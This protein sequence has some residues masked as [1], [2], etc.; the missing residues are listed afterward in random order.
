M[1]VSLKKVADRV[2]VS[3]TTVSL[4][5]RG[6]RK[7]SD[8]T[9]RKVLKV[10]RELGY[11]PNASAKA[12]VTGWS[13][14]LGVTIR[15]IHYLSD[16]YISSIMAGVAEV[17]DEK[18]LSLAF[19]R[20]G[21]QR[22]EEAEYIQF[23]REGRFAG[24]I[25]I[26]QMAS[27]RELRLLAEMNVPT[28]LVDRR[29]PGLD[30]PVVRVN[31]CEAARKATSHLIGL[32]HKRIGVVSGTEK[33]FDFSEKLRGYAEALKAHDM[34]LDENLVKIYDGSRETIDV[35]T[36][37]KEKIVNGLLDLPEPPTAFLCFIA[38]V[39]VMCDVIRFRGLRIPEDVSVICFNTSGSFQNG[40]LIGGVQVPGY[41]MGKRACQLMLDMFEGQAATKDVVLEAK[42][43]PRRS[44]LPPSKPVRPIR[45]AGLSGHDASSTM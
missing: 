14:L 8:Q 1:S 2:N 4:A 43:N 18:G 29:V 21:H 11:R 20:S 23:A 19:A 17:S 42:F 24:E 33:L 44:C 26:D 30:L 38:E 36:W 40:L 35:V 16:P 6:H 39:M 7:I 25:I 13:D 5:M 3:T 37:L 32:G 27:K 34:P 31:Y 12:L 22:F 10:A 28:V 45:L 9:R 41:E 15:E